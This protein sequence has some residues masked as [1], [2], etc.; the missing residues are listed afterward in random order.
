MATKTTLSY[1]AK[2]V[3]SLPKWIKLMLSWKGKKKTFKR[4]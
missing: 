3:H 4:R 2:K 1:I